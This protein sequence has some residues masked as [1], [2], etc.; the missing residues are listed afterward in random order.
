M[1]W[2]DIQLRAD[3][4]SEDPWWVEG[5]FNGGKAEQKGIELQTEWQVN[6]RFS[7]EV[8]GFLA[9]PE[10]SESFTTPAGSP[11]EAGWP[12]PDS[13]DQKLWAAF[14]YRVPGFLIQDGEFWTR[15]SYSYQG[16][17]WNNLTAIRC[18]E[19]PVV[20]GDPWCD[21]D[22]V[23]DAQDQLVPSWSTST[24]QF[25]LSSNNGWDAALIVRNLFDEDAA[26]YMSSSDYGA[27]FGDPRFRYR[28]TPQRPRSVS[29]SFTKRW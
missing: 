8:G 20:D 22:E 9:D 27:F 29:L 10:F 25:G 23:A 28:V 24:L 4:S 17:F 3:A 1:E 13:P 26:G 18:V 11:V 5:I 16:E 6:D 7:F 2:S 14:E 12:M 19:N 15:L 21:A